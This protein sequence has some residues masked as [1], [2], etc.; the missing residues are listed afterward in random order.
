MVGVIGEK[1]VIQKELMTREVAEKMV[2]QLA[3]WM[4]LMS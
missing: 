2:V 4:E 1:S 3:T